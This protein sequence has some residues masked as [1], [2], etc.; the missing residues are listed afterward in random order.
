[1]GLYI[2]VL[3]IPKHRV[4]NFLMV[5]HL[6]TIG[7]P[8]HK[9]L[10]LELRFFEGYDY[11]EE[12]KKKIRHIEEW[13]LERGI[14]NRFSSSFSA[15][16]AI[17]WGMHRILEKISN[18]SEASLVLE[19]DARLQC[20]WGKLNEEWESL[21]SL[22]GYARI[23]SLQLWHNIKKGKR[24]NEIFQRGGGTG[25][26][27]TIWTPHGAQFVL[28]GLRLPQ[29]GNDRLESLQG[30]DP[31]AKGW[32]SSIERQVTQ[33]VVVGGFY[34]HFSSNLSQRN[35]E[36]QR[37]V[38]GESLFSDIRMSRKEVNKNMTSVNEKIIFLSSVSE[39]L[40][41]LT[42][43]VARFEKKVQLDAEEEPNSFL[44]E[45]LSRMRGTLQ[46]MLGDVIVEG[47]I[48]EQ[49]QE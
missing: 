42:A 40:K 48:L 5:G 1:M 25:Q 45:Q 28:D 46:T 11:R 35:A 49:E 4:R 34:N 8:I 19:C 6:E 24:I 23:K 44:K 7:V 9:M 37:T 15:C 16:S 20:S 18:E 2:K 13:H 43:E 36:F 29:R 12:N 47:T 26:M 3:T 30:T 38:C 27:G 33:S 14:Q 31:F 10:G 22:E 17:E 32:Y 41:L 39:K 21:C